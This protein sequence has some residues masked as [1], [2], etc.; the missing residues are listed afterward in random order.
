M[1]MKEWSIGTW[2]SVTDA[3]QWAY[4]LFVAAIWWG[5]RMS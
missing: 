2:R 1:L 3:E 4:R 5:K